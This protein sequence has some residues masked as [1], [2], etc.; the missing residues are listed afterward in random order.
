ME[1]SDI[2]ISPA[3]YQALV[4]QLAEVVIERERYIDTL[5]EVRGKIMPAVGFMR[6]DVY[7]KENALRYVESALTLIEIAFDGTLHVSLE[8]DMIKSYQQGVPVEKIETRRG[9]R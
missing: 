2:V 7:S 5:K 6:C 4:E 9:I 3:Q 1:V 8:Q